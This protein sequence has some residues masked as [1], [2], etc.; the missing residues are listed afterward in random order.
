MTHTAWTLWAPALAT[1]PQ[2]PAIYPSRTDG[3]YRGS[4]RLGCPCRPFLPRAERRSPRR[5]GRYGQTAVAPPHLPPRLDIMGFRDATKATVAQSQAPS[6]AADAS[7]TSHVCVAGPAS[8]C[9]A[10]GGG[11][12]QHTSCVS[13]SSPNRCPPSPIDPPSAMVLLIRRLMTRCRV[14]SF[15]GAAAVTPTEMQVHVFHG[16]VGPAFWADMP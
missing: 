9:A 7:Q 13:W 8:A 5:L 2:G 14:L 12:R 11:G 3:C 10:T 1:L 6:G 16:R 15:R 4:Q